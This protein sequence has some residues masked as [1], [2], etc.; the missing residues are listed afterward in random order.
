MS[1]VS[2]LKRVVL[3]STLAAASAAW[4][5]AQA[6][7]IPVAA[8]AQDISATLPLA[9]R[10]ADRLLP[11]GIYREMMSSTF[12]RMTSSMMNSMGEI[13]LR[14]FL[15]ASGVDD[16]AVSD[17]DPA[18]L[19]Q[20][21]SILDPYFTE[22][23]DRGMKAMTSLIV[24]MM[25]KYEPAVREG[26]AEAYARRFTAAQLTDLERFFATPTGSAYAAQSMLIY[27]DPAVMDRMMAMMPKMMEDAPRM[28]AAMQ[29]ATKDLPKPRTYK[30]LSAE[31]RNRLADML[32][33]DPRKMKK[34]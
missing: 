13:P 6:Q 7:N 30:D 22:R 12:D 34:Q 26:V 18:T 25:E 29:E 21:M 10:I 1:A 8:P 27:T 24:E 31:E 14:T 9:T 32:G 5:P 19:N 28:V 2:V 33:I 17:A 23:N 11:K 3:A 16:G 15:K 4:L 20:V